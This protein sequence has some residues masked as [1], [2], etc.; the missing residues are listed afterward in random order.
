MCAAQTWARIC[1]AF[2][3]IHCACVR[4]ATT[5]NSVGSRA[6]TLALSMI[7]TICAKLSGPSTVGRGALRSS[8]VRLDIAHSV[9]ERRSSMTPLTL[10]CDIPEPNGDPPVGAWGSINCFL[11]LSDTSSG[12]TG[13][14]FSR[15]TPANKVRV[16]ACR[17]SGVASV[18]GAGAGTVS[19][20]V[21][22]TAW[23]ASHHARRSLPVTWGLVCNQ[24]SSFFR[25]SRSSRSSRADARSSRSPRSAAA[26]SLFTHA[27]IS[28]ASAG[29]LSK[30]LPTAFF[31]DARSSVIKRTRKFSA[32]GAVSISS[33][34]LLS[35]N[36]LALS[37]SR[38]S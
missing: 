9:R 29:P 36:R 33:P 21:V 12:S 7:S 30:T 25:P 23:V 6:P 18:T 16:R 24:S 5:C 31:C 2:R 37:A 14:Y 28:S 22:C 3:A 19:T 13:G 32:I 35:S 38:L 34:G 4:R 1:L 15:M 8:S 11:I 20:M 27:A 10:P 17:A 26:S